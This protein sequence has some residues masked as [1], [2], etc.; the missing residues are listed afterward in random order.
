MIIIYAP[1]KID[2]FIFRFLSIIGSS[3]YVFDKNNVVRSKSLKRAGKIHL[4][5]FDNE[6]KIGLLNYI[7]YPSEKII[8]NYLSSLRME[9][10]YRRLSRLYGR[11]DNLHQKLDLSLVSTFNY[12]PRFGVCFCVS[13]RLKQDERLTIINC[14]LGSFISHEYKIFD[15]RCIHILFPLGQFVN[16]FSEYIKTRWYKILRNKKKIRSN[17]LTEVF[18]IIRTPIW[19][20]F[21][22]KAINMAGFLGKSITFH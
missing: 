9:T 11:I 17:E 20:Y 1:T 8:E 18:F 10:T 7:D 12:F 19:R 21:S 3:I 14:E 5:R 2:L 15:K 4:I 22:I 13:N 6:D 16:I